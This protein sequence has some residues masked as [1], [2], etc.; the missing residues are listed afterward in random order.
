LQEVPGAPTRS[1]PLDELAMVR[2]PGVA[3]ACLLVSGPPL[4]E[5]AMLWWTP[6][7]GLCA[8][9]SSFCAW[10]ERTHT[11]QTPPPCD[12]RSPFSITASGVCVSCMRPGLSPVRPC[13]FGLAAGLRGQLD[14]PSPSQ[15]FSLSKPSRRRVLLGRQ[16]G[17]GLV[18]ESRS[19]RGDSPPPLSA[20]NS[21]YTTIDA[22]VRLSL[23]GSML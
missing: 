22:R 17:R 1:P 3:R 10:G 13:H 7:R 19:R 23:F 18:S 16:A 8:G 4:D 5:L 12:P 20:S 15:R 21:K 9:V 6:G 2:A 14:S 11:R